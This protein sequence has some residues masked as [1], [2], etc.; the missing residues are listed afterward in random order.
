[1]RKA[2]PCLPYPTEPI[3]QF[4]NRENKHHKLSALYDASPGAS[5]LSYRGMI[6]SSASGIPMLLPLPMVYVWQQQYVCAGVPDS[7]ASYLS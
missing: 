6:P 3:G 7:K 4:T 1:M 5:E 2:T